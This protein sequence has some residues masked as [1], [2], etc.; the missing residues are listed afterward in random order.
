LQ[1][2]LTAAFNDGTGLCHVCQ[3]NPATTYGMCGDCF[4]RAVWHLDPSW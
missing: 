3:R 1:H 2:L 4:S